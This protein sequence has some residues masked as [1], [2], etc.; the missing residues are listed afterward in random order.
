MHLVLHHSFLILTFVGILFIVLYYI[1]N[2]IDR[3]L[4]GL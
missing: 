4:A 1:Y 3:E 2:T